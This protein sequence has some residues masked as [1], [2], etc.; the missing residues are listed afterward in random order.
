MRLSRLFSEMLLAAAAAWMIA[1][2]PALVV[3]KSLH[4]TAASDGFDGTLELLAD[5]RLTPELEK[6]LW[7]SGGPD[8]ALDESDARYKTFA[9]SPLKRAV[10]RLRDASQK[11]VFEKTLDR[12]LARLRVE[13]LHSGQ[14][15][16]LVTTDL[17]IGMGSYAGPLTELYQVKAGR[18][19][20]VS[21]R[22]PQSG[23]TEPIALMSSLKTAWKMVS[24]NPAQT[25]R[26]D[27]LEVACRPANWSSL[28]S[29]FV[30]IYTRYH[31]DGKG[32]I[33]FTR[34]VHGFWEDDS[35]FPSPARFP[36]VPDEK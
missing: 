25:D 22:N 26:K 12:E 33:E 16:V 32:W 29:D 28:K 10:V 2:Q 3:S 11:I 19:E 13:P 15:T 1:Q 6:M 8:M 23:R 34:R 30:V 4:L 14:R 36:S 20:A 21:A 35:G 27:I 7:D 31:W 17:S 24:P 9:S 5:A 18:L